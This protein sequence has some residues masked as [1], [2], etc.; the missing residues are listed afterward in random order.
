ML[1][2]YVNTPYSSSRSTQVEA[3]PWLK[4]LVT[5]LSQ[6]MSRLNPKPCHVGFVVDNMALGQAF[7]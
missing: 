2:V 4:Q 7:H 3:M 1:P 6:Q 5:D